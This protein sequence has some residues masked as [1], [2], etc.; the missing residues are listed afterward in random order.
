M[1]EGLA[2]IL[3]VAG[4]AI[5]SEIIQKVME[6]NGQGGKVMFIRIIGYVGCGIIAFNYWWDGLRSIV[7]IFGVYI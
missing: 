3:K 7:A 4:I 1:I 5:G 2:P 6:E